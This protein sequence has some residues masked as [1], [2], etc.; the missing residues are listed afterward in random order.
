MC[1]GV[2]YSE[3]KQKKIL[4]K[5]PN[6]IE[7][8][9]VVRY[10]GKKYKAEIKNFSFLTR[11]NKA[12]HTLRNVDPGGYKGG[13]HSFKS[14]H[15]AKEWK[16]GG[17]GSELIIKCKIK[18]AWITAIGSQN[19]VVFVTNKI[20]MPSPRTRDKIMAGKRNVRG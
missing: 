4:D 1:L 13:F 15:G 12:T 3:E 10:S 7:V 19:G 8:Y 11:L 5:L 14:L 9:K 6:V 17:W 18:K 16:Y 20:I 2:V